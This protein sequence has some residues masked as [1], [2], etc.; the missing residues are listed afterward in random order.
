MGRD[1]F[2]ILYLSLS[3]LFQST[4]PVWGATILHTV[5]HLITIFQSTRPVWGATVKPSLPSPSRY[6]Y[7]NP[8]APYGARQ[9]G[10]KTENTDNI[11]IHAPRMG[12]DYRLYTSTPYISRFQSTRP[13][14][15]ATLC[16]C[17]AVE[18]QAISIHAPRMG[19]DVASDL[20]ELKVQL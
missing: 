1:L 12:R 10:A 18:I 6:T 20:Y 5:P 8:R 15:G 11:S 13:V 19:R 9:R 7:F 16:I 4:R 14:W 3:G 17:V 2:P